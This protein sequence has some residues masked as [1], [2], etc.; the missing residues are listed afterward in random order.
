L[1]FDCVELGLRDRAAV[2]QL[3]RFVDLR[4]CAGHLVGVGA[5][6]AD[7]GEHHVRVLFVADPAM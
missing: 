2:E 3:L 5:W 6:H 7:I 1:A 4:R